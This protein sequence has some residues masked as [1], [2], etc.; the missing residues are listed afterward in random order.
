MEYAY[1][2]LM[3]CFSGLLLLYAAALG[4]TGD[5]SMIV[6][7]YAAKMRDPKAYARKFA[8]AVALAALAPLLSGLVAL[9]HWYVA[10]VIVLIVGLGLALFLATVIMRDET[11]E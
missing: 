1:S 9:P 3:F 2:I 10:A 8:G 11:R 5:A 4:A 6:R 7:S